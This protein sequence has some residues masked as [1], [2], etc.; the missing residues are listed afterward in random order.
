[1]IRKPTALDIAYLI[2]ITA[3]WASVFPAIKVA[4]PSLGPVWIATIRVFLGFLVLLPWTLWRG[5]ILPEGAGQWGLVVLLALLNA[6][7]PFFFISYA[8]LHISAGMIALL[9]GTGPF[10]ALVLSHFTTDDERLNWLKLASV[11]FGFT[12]VAIIVGPS[13]FGEGHGSLLGHAAVLAGSLCYVISGVLIR[14]I[15]GIP[16]TRL[17][18]L[19]LAL[20]SLI[21]LPIA[22]TLGQPDWGSV[23][24]SA[25]QAVIY[26]GI[27]PTGLG[28][29]ARYHLVRTVGYSFFALGLN[30]IPVFGVALGALLLGEAITVKVIAALVLVLTGLLFARMGANVQPRTSV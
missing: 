27:L 30:L 1:M 14:R 20:S 18:T 3:I 4:V 23:P 6:V 13:A 16:P 7:V 17:S 8:G 10:F 22:F 28:Y 15:R 19:V 29:L 12:G 9:M 5:I 26:L 2:A 11:A 25:M 24:N 21:L